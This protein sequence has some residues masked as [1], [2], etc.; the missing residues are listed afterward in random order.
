[1][2]FIMRV[3]LNRNLLTNSALE[4]NFLKKSSSSVVIRVIKNI[5]QSLWFPI[6]IGTEFQIMF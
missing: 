6:L 5:K 4:L 1:M 3:I 2:K